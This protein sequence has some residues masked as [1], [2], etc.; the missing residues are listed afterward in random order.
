[1][2]NFSIYSYIFYDSESIGLF[3][4]SAPTHAPMTAKERQATIPELVG[5]KGTS[6]AMKDISNSESYYP[7][8][9]IL[10]CGGIVLLHLEHPKKVEVWMKKETK[11]G[12]FPKIDKK[13][14]ASNPYCY[15]L[16][17]CREGH[18][19]IAVEIVTSAWRKT[20]Q[21]QVLLERNLNILFNN[22]DY[23]FNIRISPETYSFDFL[24][25]SRKLIRKKGLKVTKMII[26]FKRGAI[27]PIVEATVKHNPFIRMLFYRMFASSKADISL[28]YPDVSTLIRKNSQLGE[29]FM[30]LIGS[31]QD[32]G[33]GVKMSYSNHR[34]YVWGDDIRIEFPMKEVVFNTVF[35][36]K[37]L[38]EEQNNDAS[39]KAMQK[40]F[41]EL[42]TEIEKERHDTYSKSTRTPEG[43]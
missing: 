9:V 42:E 27:D 20:D 38:F 14:V 2:R 41:D 37:Y 39:E 12:E 33:F 21:V 8:T 11:P 28:D 34:S 26:H 29:M 1:M 4:D 36:E 35:E 18:K 32:D 3:K 19:L 17:D 22:Q 5:K 13:K 24:E 23:R 10:N 25:H 43:A 30:M 40:W 31:E 7:C 16:I 15:I 6:F